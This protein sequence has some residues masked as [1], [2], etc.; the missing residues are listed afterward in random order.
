[1]ATPNRL[2]DG[3]YSD[4]STNGEFG[5]TILGFILGLVV[6]LSAALAIAFYLSKNT[7]QERPG[8]RAPNLPLTIKPVPPNADGEAANETSPLDLN[9]PLQGK[10]AANNA[11]GADPIGEIAIGK[12]T[13]ESNSAVKSSDTKTTESKMD[14][15]GDPVYFVQTG[16]FSKR[17]DADSQKAML[18]MEGMQSQMSE[19]LADGN[20]IWRVRIGPYSTVEDSNS[21]RDKLISIGI[22]PTIIKANKS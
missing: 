9:K 19:S 15:R 3:N 20:T 11:I 14:S 8:V 22:K 16:A 21:V 7:P 17:T 2:N 5:G 1:M 12:K 13:A 4:R 18:A 6:G 10:P